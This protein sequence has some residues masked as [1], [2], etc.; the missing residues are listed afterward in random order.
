MAIKS[1][2]NPRSDGTDSIRDFEPDENETAR[3]YLESD[4]GQKFTTKAYDPFGFVRVHVSK[5]SVPVE[6]SGQYTSFME[7]EQSIEAYLRK[8]GK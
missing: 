8:K 5:G 2:L 1:R 7:A 4:D 6:L 3:R